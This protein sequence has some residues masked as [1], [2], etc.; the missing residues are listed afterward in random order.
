[1]IRTFVR[2]LDEDTFTEL[3]VEGGWERLVTSVILR[4]LVV[5]QFEVLVEDE[6]GELVPYEEYDGE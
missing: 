2:D 6:D 1:M 4:S 3:R 5:A